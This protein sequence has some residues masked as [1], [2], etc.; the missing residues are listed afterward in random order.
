MLVKY[1]G[2][3]FGVDG[4]TDGKE[5]SVV[6]YEEEL[7]WLRVIDDS[8]EDYLYNPVHPRPVADPKHP[9]GRFEIVED[10]ENQ[11]LK[12]AIYGN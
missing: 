12:R 8:G 11:T 10:D 1:V 9:G 6:E 4:L 5:Y 2:E 3:S 7:G